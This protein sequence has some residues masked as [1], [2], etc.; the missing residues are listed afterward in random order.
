M[1]NIKTENEHYKECEIID[2][3]ND[4]DYILSISSNELGF[5]SDIGR[6]KTVNQ[7]YAKVGYRDD[8]TAIM[9]VADGVTTSPYSGE[10][11]K[12]ICDYLFNK[13]K[14]SNSYNKKFL[15]K[16]IMD[17]NKEINKKQKDKRIK[18]IQEEKRTLAYL[19]TLVV[20]IVKKSEVL[21]AWL[22]D[23]R[24]YFVNDSKGYLLTKDDSLVNAMIDRGE[25]NE[26]EAETH[27]KKNIITQCVGFNEN[28][29][30]SHLLKINMGFYRFPSDVD[31]ILCSDGLWSE[32]DL[33]E[34]VEKSKTI[35]MT[36]MKLIKKANKN[37]G[38]DNITCALYKKI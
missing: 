27:P 17:L 31:L 3:D 32:V 23:S 36:L 7:D 22:G 26:L 30:K 10:S 29:E 25:I 21:I 1:N 6:K 34:G 20:A 28:S 2:Y 16:S 37:G 13:L 12:F 24:A 38:S 8:D 35:E 11:A 33:K 18:K 4:R 9:I 15:A 19:S 14:Q 5:I